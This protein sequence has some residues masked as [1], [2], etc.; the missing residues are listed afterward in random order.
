MTRVYLVAIIFSVFIALIF[1][2]ENLLYEPYLVTVLGR[3]VLLTGQILLSLMLMST[4]FL[5]IGI[6]FLE[7]IIKFFKNRQIKKPKEMAK[8]KKD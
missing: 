3:E 8:L 5:L 1:N 6:G 7:N 2:S 4:L